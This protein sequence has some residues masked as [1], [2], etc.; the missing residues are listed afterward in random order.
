MSEARSALP[1]AAFAGVVRVEEAGLRG[2]VTLRAE[3]G[4]AKVKKAVKDA[5]GTDIPAVRKAALAGGRGALWMSPDETPPPRPPRR[6]TRR[7]RP[8]R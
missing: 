1:G 5:M 2:M 3:L 7:R 6:G 8:P 4:A